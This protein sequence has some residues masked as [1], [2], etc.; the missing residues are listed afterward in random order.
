MHRLYHCFYECE[1]LQT[2]NRASSLDDL[3]RLGLVKH[4]IS[5]TGSS[6]LRPDVSK[7][8]RTAEYSR[9]DDGRRFNIAAIFK[10]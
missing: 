6:D 5:G 2:T 1:I 9:P 8:P 7:G 4:N 10:H 3:F